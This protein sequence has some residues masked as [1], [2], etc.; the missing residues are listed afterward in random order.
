MKKHI[1]VKFKLIA[2]ML[3]V[4]AVPLGVAVFISYMTS[5]TKAKADAQKRFAN[6][7]ARSKA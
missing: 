7:E 3:A 4:A 2:I 5:S 1:S 6:L